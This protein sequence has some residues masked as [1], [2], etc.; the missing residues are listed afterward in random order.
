MHDLRFAL[1]GFR[2]S[3][4]FMVAALGTLA[5]GIGAN[6]A[7]F[8]IVSGVLGRIDPVV[9]AGVI[10][11][12]SFVALLATAIPATRAARVDPTYALRYE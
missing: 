3:P 11:I 1:R 2:K 4:A 7:M 10:L 6:S 8:T 5:L 9:Y 12:L